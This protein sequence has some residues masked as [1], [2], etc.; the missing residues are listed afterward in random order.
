[1]TC[2]ESYEL[3]V[4]VTSS[5]ASYDLHAKLHVSR[6]NGVREYVVPLVREDLGI[7]LRVAN[8]SRQPRSQ[9]RAQHQGRDLHSGIVITGAVVEVG[10]VRRGQGRDCLPV[11]AG[12]HPGAFV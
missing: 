1:M 5:S 9:L 4:E 2:K 12:T 11:I 7:V 6:R 8:P 10:V 3:V